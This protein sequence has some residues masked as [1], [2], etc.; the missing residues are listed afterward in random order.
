MEMN[1]RDLLRYALRAPAALAA[2]RLFGSG[3][4]ALL[5]AQTLDDG[6]LP[7]PEDSGIDHIV[8]VMMENR[9]FDHFMG[10][11]P[12]A[13]GL[14]PDGLVYVDRGGN[15]YSTYPLV[16]DYTGQG[17]A[18]PNHSYSGSR[19]DYNG[20]A[21]DGF[22]KASGNDIYCIGYYVESDHAFLAPLARQYTTCDRYFSSFLGPTYPN[23]LFAHA[24]Q[25]DRLSNTSALATMPTIWD[26]LAA[27]G[28]SG[29]YYAQGTP[30]LRLWGSQYAGITGTW[31]EFLDD[32]AAGTLPA[33]SFVDPK[34]GFD[35][36][37]HSDIRTGDDWLNQT[38]SA[39]NSG[40]AWPSTVVIITFDEGGG[41]F[42]HVAPPR[43]A[44]PNGVDP[45]VDDDGNVLLGFRVP[46]I[47]ASPF[48]A[49]TPDDP[50]VSH[51][52]FD[53]TSVLKLIEWRWDLAP[54][55]ARDAS[56][57]V[58]NLACALT[59]QGV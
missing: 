56:D 48:S 36:H 13:D 23:R 54:L 29:R 44:A 22:L 14:P 11:L 35:D 37:P 3:G 33:V 52:P 51:L 30:F 34:G 26:S 8:F 42:D 21:M 24:A 12:N 53:H 58:G 4:G 17:F 2:A 38:F 41:F 20:G 5:R 40:P 16:P 39:V 45:D 18:D 49:G 32:A 15:P 47:I 27:A 6:V 50:T 55:T 43:A 57:D 1:R 7:S 31:E 9:S 10:W 25:T 28:I 19:V 46:A 59:F